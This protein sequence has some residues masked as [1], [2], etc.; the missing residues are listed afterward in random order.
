MSASTTSP[1]GSP[2]SLA[3]TMGFSSFGSKPNPKKKRKL[4]QPSHTGSGSNSTPLGTSRRQ[5]SELASRLDIRS[6][7]EFAE[8]EDGSER[9]ASERLEA[10]KDE[11]GDGG[12]TGEDKGGP[13]PHIFS[14]ARASDPRKSNLNDANNTPDLRPTSRTPTF[15][16]PKSLPP[17]P[18]PPASSSFQNVRSQSPQWPTQLQAPPRT[19]QSPQSHNFR[20]LRHGLRDENGDMAYYDESFVEDPWRALLG[21]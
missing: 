10:E 19:Q 7:K 5:E 2:I 17:R 13:V 6:E 21:M 3:Q 18:S 15:H 9:E 8:G 20:S 12:S 16:S 11:D 14:N 1:P 4:Q